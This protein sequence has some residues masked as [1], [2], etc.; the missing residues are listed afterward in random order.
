MEEFPDTFTKAINTLSTHNVQPKPEIHKS[1]QNNNCGNNKQE[2]KV[3][4]EIEIPQF[5]SMTM[6]ERCYCCGKKG[7]KSPQC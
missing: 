6:E 5:T 2:N 3:G 7:H 4:S 1:N